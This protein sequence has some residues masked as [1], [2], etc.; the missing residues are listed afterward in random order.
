M[1]KIL[2]FGKKSSDIFSIKQNFYIEN[3]IL[4]SKQKKISKIYKKQP[5]EKKFPAS[6]LLQALHFFLNGCFL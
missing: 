5:L 1:N 3:D 4:L 6:F 2:K